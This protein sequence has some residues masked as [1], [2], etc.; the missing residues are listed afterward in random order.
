MSVFPYGESEMRCARRAGCGGPITEEVD[1]E[2]QMV[3]S[4]CCSCFG[5]CCLYEQRFGRHDDNHDRSSDDD[6]RN[7]NNGCD[8]ND[9][10]R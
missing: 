1:R 8:D 7:H 2:R 5:R 3:P 6:D 10:S 9:R 4:H